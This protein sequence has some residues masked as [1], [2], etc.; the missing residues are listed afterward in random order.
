MNQAVVIAGRQSR[1]L[2]PPVWHYG[3]GPGVAPSAALCKVD[4]LTERVGVATRDE[5]SL[6]ARVRQGDLPAFEELIEPYEGRVYQSVLRVLRNSADAAD[7]YQEAVLAA[8]EK[9]GDFSGASGFGTWLHRIAINRALMRLRSASREPVISE[10]DLPSF[11]WMGMM[12]K[13]PVSNWADS[14]ELLNQRAELRNMLAE[15]LEELPEVDRAVVWLKDV[16]GLS[17][18]DIAEATGLT[19]SAARSRLHR[20][21][22]W[23]RGRF[24]RLL[25][26]ER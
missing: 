4:W 6:I 17:H 10:E 3:P 7:V 26:G 19:V 1:T 23:L 11:N 12:H 22:L 15:A 24:E 25:G 21:R 2:P 8:F 9:I 5:G 16:E 13:E 18:Q 20:A 14:P